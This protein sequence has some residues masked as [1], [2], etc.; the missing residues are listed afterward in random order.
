MPALL[1]I[2]ARSHCPTGTTAPAPDERPSSDVVA[3]VHLDPDEPLPLDASRE[4]VVCVADGLVYLTIGDEDV[5]LMSGER[6]ALRAGDDVRAWNA[7]DEPARVIV[8]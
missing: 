8:A 6:V 4:N 2:P 1:H 5:I 7:G 3:I